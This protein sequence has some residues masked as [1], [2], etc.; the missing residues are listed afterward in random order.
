VSIKTAIIGVGQTGYRFKRTDVTMQELAQE[1]A[2]KALEHAKMEM[3]EIEAFALGI[4]PDA[5]SAIDNVDRWIAHALG[6]APRPQLRVNTGGTTGAAAAQ[7]G[8]IHVAS[9][10][11]RTVMVL[12]ADKVSETPDAQW[13]LNTAMDPIYERS[14]ALNAINMCSFQ[15]V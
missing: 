11:F 4:A 15:A 3:D 12:A 1:A 7:A 2:A 6:V 8:Y 14:L 10:M 13:V 5:L 9:G